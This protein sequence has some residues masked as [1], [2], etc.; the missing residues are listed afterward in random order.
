MQRRDVNH[1]E[2]RTGLTL[3]SVTT[4]GQHSQM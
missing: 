1:V 3:I 2:V 4:P